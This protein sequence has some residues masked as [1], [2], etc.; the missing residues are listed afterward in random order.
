MEMGEV[1]LA[2]YAVVVIFAGRLKIGTIKMVVDG[3]VSLGSVAW[4]VVFVWGVNL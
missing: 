1:A 2:E 4:R 3:R